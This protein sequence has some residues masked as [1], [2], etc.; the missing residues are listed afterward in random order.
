M[1][2]RSYWNGCKI[3]AQHKNVFLII[4]KESCI[5]I[6]AL[7]NIYIYIYTHTYTYIY[8]CICMY[9]YKW[10][11]AHRV[12]KSHRSRMGVIYNAIIKTMCLPGCHHNSFDHLYH[13][14][15]YAP[16]IA[17]WALFGSFWYQQCVTIHHVPKWTV[18]EGNN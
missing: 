6:T 1:H 11:I 2:R 4:F 5:I 8:I 18:G 16:C 14:T 10:S 3:S 9:I 7:K 17:C 12:L 13:L 15:T